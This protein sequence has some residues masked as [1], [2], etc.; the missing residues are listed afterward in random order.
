MTILRPGVALLSVVCAAAW[1]SASPQSTVL[2]APIRNSYRTPG[3]VSEN[4]VVTF[5]DVATLTP[6]MRHAVAALRSGDY[7]TAIVEF[8]VL[9]RSE[10]SNPLAFRG[11]TQAALRLD[12][13]RED[14]RSFDELNRASR[15]PGPSIAD[16][17]KRF[18]GLLHRATRNLDRAALE[19]ALGDALMAARGERA[20]VAAPRHDLGPEPEEHLK[21]ALRLSPRMLVAHLS[22][23]AYY[24]YQAGPHGSRGS[25]AR[26]EYVAAIAL[27][28]DLACELRFLHALT[29]S[30]PGDVSQREV[31]RLRAQGLE[32]PDDQ[33]MLPEKTIAECQALIRDF[34][35]YGPAYQKIADLYQWPLGNKAMAEK[36]RKMV[37]ELRAKQKGRQ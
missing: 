19:Y 8:R 26:K 16:T 6:G 4:G 1:S 30:R 14:F 20:W 33:K 5:E 12:S 24:D 18:A 36:Y 23:A 21:A 31:A 35:E 17:V 29:W 2:K 13:A 7:S 27:R 9:Q 3:Y 22:L 11:E 25:L 28:P 10:P 37:D 15:T 32:L 34:P